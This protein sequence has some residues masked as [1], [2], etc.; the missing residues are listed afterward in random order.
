MNFRDRN[1]VIIISCTESLKG[2]A[3]LSK[4]HILAT[5]TVR[6]GGPARLR[7]LLGWQE[8]IH[9]MDPPRSKTAL[10]NAFAGNS[11]DRASYVVALLVNYVTVKL[12]QL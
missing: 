10:K 5:E 1:Y 2:A 3:F 12:L 7:T 8:L 11:I 6:D 9:P 4:M